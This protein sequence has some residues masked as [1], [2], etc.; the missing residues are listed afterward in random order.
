MEDEP[1]LREALARR[2]SAL[3]EA[4]RLDEFVRMYN[5]LRGRSSS[6]K[7]GEPMQH[8]APP[9]VVVGDNSRSMQQPQQDSLA[10][11]FI[12]DKSRPNIR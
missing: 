10:G 12:L 3:A 4:R 1:V 8:Q 11:E 5:E 2:D 6:G 7:Y 9:L